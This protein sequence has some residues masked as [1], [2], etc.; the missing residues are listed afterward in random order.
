MLSVPLSNPYQVA[1]PLCAGHFE[2]RQVFDSSL[3]IPD[4]RL[5]EWMWENSST[6]RQCPSSVACNRSY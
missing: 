6:E 2:S 5:Q 4:V 1:E 3:S